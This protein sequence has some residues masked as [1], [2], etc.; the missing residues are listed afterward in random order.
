MTDT[1]PPKILLGTVLLETERWRSG[2]PTFRVS[3]WMGRIAD[4]GF[5]G[6]ELWQ[7]HALRADE[8]ERA[9]IA[10]STL[11]VHCFNSYLTFTDD[12]VDDVAPVADL[13]KRLRCRTVK[14][15][16]LNDPA[17]RDE[18]LRHISAFAA[19]LPAE[20]RLLCEC[21]N[22]TLADTPAAAS[23]L[24]DALGSADRFGA[25]VHAFSDAERLGA[26]FDR[27]GDRIV[28]AHCTLPPPGGDADAPVGAAVCR[29]QSLGFTGT[30]TIEF[31]DRVRPHGADIGQLFD[32]AVRDLVRLRLALETA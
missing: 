29:M 11:P 12:S 22:K 4:A 15:N 30:W 23:E 19:M 6:I 8:S 26:W 3:E 7:N 10:R 21:H 9:A 20:V 31:T 18:Q 1:P 24:L 14:F 16:F 2:L 27:L 28:H 17:L 5:D 13:I 25:I 32:S